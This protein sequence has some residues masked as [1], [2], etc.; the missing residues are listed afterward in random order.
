MIDSWCKS[1]PPSG[2][3][4]PASQIPEAHWQLHDDFT[5]PVA[6]LRETALAHNLARMRE[7][8]AENEVRIAPHGKTTMSP[9]LIARQLEHGA[10]AMTAATAWQARTML[11]FG[12]RRII[13]ANE[14]HDPVG[15]RWI[16]EHVRDLPD[17][18]VFVFVDS[19][20][21]VELMRAVLRDVASPDRMRPMPVLVE[22]GVAG[23]RAGAR[24]VD[25][26]VQVGR[27]VAAAPEM[28]LA[29]AA[30]FEGVLGG[31]RIPE[32]VE[33]VRQFLSTIRHT[34]EELMAAGAFRSGHPVILSAGGS[35]FFD[36]VVDVFTTDR[37]HYPQPVDVVIRSGCYITHDHATYR[38]SSPFRETG[39]TDFQPAIEVWA[40]VV[41][42]P[43][44]GLAI[45]DAGKRDLSTDAR[46]P[47]ALGRFREGRLEQLADVTVDHFNDQHGYLH[48]AEEHGDLLRVGDLVQLGISH[49]CT[50]FDKWRVIPVV[51]DS[52]RVI[53][54]IRTCF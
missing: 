28:E 1:F 9:E 42:T 4:L 8:C 15:L 21:A 34:A 10:W 24:D 39:E 40:R 29:G 11:G 54:A 6:A 26:A 27:A 5:T 19:L 7:Y 38:E 18:E 20:A 22:V 12:A 44:P 30:G 43:E 32:I 13:I 50:T 3:G 47:L 45:I 41:S 46:M 16:A 35:A 52:Y 25:T 14:C 49:P 53:S 36:L 17:V 23:G 48:L 2:A 51:D 33:P 37:D 31:Q